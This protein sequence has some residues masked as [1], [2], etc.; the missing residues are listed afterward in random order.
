MLRLVA[1]AAL[2]AALTA[3]AAPATAQVTDDQRACNIGRDLTRADRIEACT[4]LIDA[5]AGNI[6]SFRQRRGELLTADGNYDAA[7]ADFD[8]VIADNASNWGARQSRAIVY[9]YLDRPEDAL[10]DLAPALEALPRLGYDYYLRGLAEAALGDLDTAV[11]DFD[12]AMH[13]DFALGW[14]AIQRGVLYLQQGRPD[15]ARAEFD[16]AIAADP[17]DGRA[18]DGLGRIA[19]AAGDTAE[20]IRGYRLAQ[21][22]NPNLAT[23]ATRLPELVPPQTAADQGPL[24]FAPPVE[25]LQ[26]E[27]MAVEYPTVPTGEA[28]AADVGDVIN[29]FGGPPTQPVPSAALSTL[30]VLGATRTTSTP[31]AVTTLS[32]NAALVG[33][34]GAYDHAL[35]PIRAPAEE[36]EGWSYVYRGLDDLWQLAPGGTA[37]G[38]GRLMLDCPQGTDP[39][40]ATLGCEPNV[41]NIRGGTFEWTATFVGWEYVLVPA[42]YRLTAR[43]QYD[44]VTHYGFGA[45]ITDGE[46]HMTIWYDP[47]IHWWVKRERTR[48]DVVETTEAVRITLP[49]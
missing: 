46:E 21:L 10:A 28:P 2:L 39:V 42:G 12:T 45:D 48:D 15:D 32:S 17:I 35:L 37:S 7:L 43:I 13:V 22:L 38:T 20:A 5:G 41:P 14:I 1:A 40:W 23:P 25:G 16:A 33:A 47:D 11:T 29:W 31:T 24:V 36:P 34:P 26:I 18:Y 3:F 30:W 6:A 27:Y 19:D 9:L 49:E 8:A 44:A 4:R